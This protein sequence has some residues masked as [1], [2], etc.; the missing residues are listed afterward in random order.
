VSCIGI[1]GGDLVQA[2]RRLLAPNLVASLL[3]LDV[4]GTLATVRALLGAGDL[5]QL[6]RV[7]RVSDTVLRLVPVGALA[8]LAA[9]PAVPALPVGI[10]DILG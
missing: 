9:L 4:A 2:V 3:D 5:T 1:D 6:V 7:E 8:D 10:I